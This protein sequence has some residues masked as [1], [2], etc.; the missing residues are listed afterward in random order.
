MVATYTSAAV[1]TLPA[2]S[3]ADG[4]QFY[5]YG[6]Y[7]VVSTLTANDLIQLCNVPNGYKILSVTLD[8]DSLDS[9][10]TAALK[11]NVGDASSTSRF[12]NQAAIGGG[13]VQSQN[14]AASTGYVYPLVTT[15]GNGGYTTIQAKAMTAAST[16][17]TGTI[18]CLVE[19]AIDNASFA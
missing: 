8:S 7:A 11:W 15:G 4:S 18:R 14:V 16:F 17:V 6:T 19:L 10:G 12:I 13:G 9:G 2:P 1:T 5:S 3:K